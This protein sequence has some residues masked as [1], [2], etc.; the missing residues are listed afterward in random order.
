M[1]LFDSFDFGFEINHSERPKEEREAV[2]HGTAH[3]VRSH[4]VAAKSVGGKICALFAHFRPSTLLHRIGG[5]VVWR[6]HRV[7]SA[8]KSKSL[9][10]VV[11]GRP[12]GPVG[13]PAEAVDESATGSVYLSFSS[14]PLRFPA[15]GM[16]RLWRRPPVRPQRPRPPC[17]SR[18]RRSTTALRTSRRR[19]RSAPAQ[20]P[21]AGTCT[22][23]ARCG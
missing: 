3:A 9:P 7:R 10:E 16:R 22:R 12:Q 18:R 5:L 20:A 4:R 11:R 14:A 17:R 13:K 8:S 1:K 23:A 6:L 2:S 15:F 19:C 21:R